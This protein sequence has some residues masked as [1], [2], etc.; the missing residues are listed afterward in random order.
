MPKGSPELTR[1]RREEII[2]ACSKLYE[3]MSFKEIT[4]KELA[5]FTSFTRPSIYNYFQTKEEIFLALLQREYE[6]WAEELDSLKP[7]NGKDNKEQLAEALA[8]SLEKRGRLLKLLS[9]NLY[10]IEENSRLECL[11]E[12][13]AVYG[14]SIESVKNCF[15]RFLPD[16]SEEEKD[17]FVFLFFPFIYGIYP[18]TAVTSKQ[19][20]SMEKA[21]IRHR[22]LS[23]Y[24]LALKGI[25]RLAAKS[26]E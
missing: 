14:A 8:R 20:E 18:Y 2:N 22:E 21:G 17:D 7:E 24:E 23:I 25:R 10:E 26:L 16:S 5:N 9:M 12:F 19:K 4:L 1:K 11:T 13:K 6:K 3:N 15:G